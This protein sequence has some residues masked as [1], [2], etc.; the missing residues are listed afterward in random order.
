MGKERK[1]IQVSIREE[2][3]AWA[4]EI[5]DAFREYDNLDVS[6]AKVV[7]M[8]LA[9]VRNDLRDKQAKKGK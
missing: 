6:R 1:R 7:E 2:A 9:K 8:C 5:G 4:D 3:G